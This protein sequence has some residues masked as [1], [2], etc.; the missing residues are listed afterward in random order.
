MLEVNVVDVADRRIGRLGGFGLGLS[1]GD[2]EGKGGGAGEARLDQ[3][4]SLEGERSFVG[5][6]A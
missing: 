4:A 5:H 1:D 6:D 3:V 2:A